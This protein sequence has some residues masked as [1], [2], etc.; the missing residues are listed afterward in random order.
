ML[1]KENYACDSIKGKSDKIVVLKEMLMTE[2]FYIIQ[3]D[4]MEMMLTLK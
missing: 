4:N 3:S 1:K 2:Y